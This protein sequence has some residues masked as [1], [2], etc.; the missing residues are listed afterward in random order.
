MQ[1]VCVHKWIFLKKFVDN[2]NATA[3]LL[4]DEQDDGTIFKIKP[5]C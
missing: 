3:S 5:L 4:M 1:F 2:N